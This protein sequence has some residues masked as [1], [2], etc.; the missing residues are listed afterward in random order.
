M[1]NRRVVLSALMLAPSLALALASARASVAVPRCPIIAP[2]KIVCVHLRFQI[3]LKHF[4][5]SFSRGVVRQQIRGSGSSSS[6]LCSC[7][8]PVPS[9]SALVPARL[10]PR[11]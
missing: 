1:K 5:D 6:R 4:N 9:P 3:L 8:M 7:V 2:G 10:A 11:R